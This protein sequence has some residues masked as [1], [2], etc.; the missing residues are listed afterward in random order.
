M[1]FQ[2]PI[3][4]IIICILYYCILT[5][6]FGGKFDAKYLELGKSIICLPVKKDQAD[7][8]FEKNH[9]TAFVDCR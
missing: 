2:I 4:C 7:I 6:F 3:Y 8:F 5:C 1:P 9:V